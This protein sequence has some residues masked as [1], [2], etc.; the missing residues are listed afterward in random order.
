MT[1]YTWT[2]K[3]SDKWDTDTNWSPNGIPGQNDTATIG[4][5]SNSTD[6]TVNISS[7]SQINIQKIDVYT[8]SS[9]N[10]YGTIVQ[11]SNG[12][13][14]DG[15]SIT[16]ETGSTANSIPLTVGSGGTV[17]IESTTATFSNL[18]V[19]SG[20]T[21]ELTGVS[22]YSLGNLNLSGHL[23]LSDASISADS[24]VDPQ[25]GSS[26][27]LNNESS[28]SISNLNTEVTVNGGSTLTLSGNY[29]SGSSVTMGTGT[30]NT[31]LL[32]SSASQPNLTIIGVATGDLVGV[33]GE[34]VSSATYTNNNGTG[35]ITLTTSSGTVTYSGVT[36]ASDVPTGTNTATL[37]N[38]E[39]LICFLAGSLI[40]TPNGDIAVENIRI[41]DEVI[42]FDW[43]NNAEITRKVVWVGEKKISVNPN[44]FDDEAGY[45]VRV[46][47]DAI[48]DGVPY[49]DMLITPEHCLFF[50]D[51]FVPVRMLV[52]GRSI[53]YDK[54]ITSYK[55]YHIETEQ[56]SVIWADGML[57]ESY[58]DTGNRVSFKQ[59][60]KVAFIGTS[61]T[62]SWLSDAGATLSVSREKV[63]P[64]FRQIEMRATQSGVASM[65]MASVLTT[66]SD[67]HLVT[68]KGQIIRKARDIN[69]HAVFMI[70]SGVNSVNFVSRTSRPSD[71]I[72]PFV[73]DRRHLGVLVGE[74]ILFDSKETYRINVHLTDATLTGWDVQESA[75][76]RWTNGN[77]IL[78]LRERQPGSVGMLS[79]LILA[80]GPY[81][82]TQDIKRP[83]AQTG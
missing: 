2:G 13:V 39:A 34:T 60:G 10:I 31:L 30:G 61:S 38:G 58:L 45:P 68:D 76:C 16:F 82:N 42:A 75:N 21:L 7:N 56:H 15:G 26:I 78:P 53:F 14:A 67:L 9:L 35:S 8:G 40:R 19:N 43:I 51:K 59:H 46:L 48:S 33:S 27:T 11:S 69:G 23:V 36:F 6:Y 66:E 18:K 70:P 57:S 49:K 81:L 20:G 72:G 37:K 50:E 54:T 44:L 22:G 52:N 47:K 25:S 29:N 73:D 17:N 80:A 5:S 28:L 71:T 55:Y 83:M 65:T 32:S 41:G 64:L 63:E 62:Q 1:S 3:T 4:S 77:A 79:V 12:I 24:S 74:I